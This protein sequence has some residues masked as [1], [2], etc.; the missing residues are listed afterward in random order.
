[1]KSVVDQLIEHHIRP[2]AQRVAVAEYVLDTCEHPSAERVFDRVRK[3]FP[4]ISR[5]T[6]YNSLNLFVRSGLLRELV[7]EEGRL[8]FDPNLDRH[9]HFV[10]EAS[11][12]ISDLPWDAVKLGRIRAPKGYR[13][14]AMHVVLRGTRTRP[15]GKRVRPPQ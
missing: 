14:D 9:H 6:V 13:I 7:L 8:V 10:D 1:M 2:S 4:M 12:A 11:G 3:R 15:A 5:A